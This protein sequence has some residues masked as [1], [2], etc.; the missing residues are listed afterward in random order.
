MV[1]DRIR[2]NRRGSKEALGKIINLSINQSLSR[3]LITS[4][5]TLIV[6]VFLFFFGGDV[7]N[8]FAFVLLVGIGVGTYSSIYVASYLLYVWQGQKDTVRATK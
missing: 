8:D 3:T 1:F 5:T 6:V 2:E 7:I 4:G